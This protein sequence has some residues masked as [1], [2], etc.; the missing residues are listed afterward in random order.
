MASGVHAWDTWQWPAMCHSLPN[1]F[2]I[3]PTC[4]CRIPFHM[5]Y[6][7][8]S[9]PPLQISS[10]STFK[11]FHY[12][13]LPSSLPASVVGNRPHDVPLASELCLGFLFHFTI[14]LRGSKSEESF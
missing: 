4:G 7:T 12:T 13:V 2:V 9:L 11:N 3:P 6:P 5:S 8:M 14:E 10:P 1:P